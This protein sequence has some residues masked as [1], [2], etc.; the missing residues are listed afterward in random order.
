MVAQGLSC[1]MWDLFSCGMWDL[2]P[3]WGI[4]SSPPALGAQSLSH[5]TTR[6][7]QTFI[8]FFSS[9]QSL[10]GIRLFVTPWTTTCTPPCPSQT[11]RAY[12]NSYLS[13]W[14]CH[15]T[16]SSSVIP[17]SSCLQPFPASG[18]FPGSQFFTSGGQSIG[19]STSASVLPMNSVL[20]SFRM[21]G[22]P[23]SPRDSQESSPRPQLKS[24]NSSVFSFLYSPALTSIH[25][26]WKNHSLD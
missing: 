2:V 12:S 18:S 5:W 3:G 10:S 1:I 19:L 26:Y 20:I 16:I 23:W 11:P 6:E 13:S 7:V 14:W 24:I 25:D 21:V 9:V 22:S 17:F 15:P 4:K 8:L